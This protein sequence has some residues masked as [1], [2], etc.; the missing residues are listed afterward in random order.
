MKPMKVPTM[1]Y[2]LR[3]RDTLSKIPPDSQAAK[4]LAL[5]LH[6]M[7]AGTQ[8]NDLRPALKHKVDL[9]LDLNEKGADDGNQE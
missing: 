1:D 8:S 6:L 7:A 2:A 9:I 3:V 5:A 4:H